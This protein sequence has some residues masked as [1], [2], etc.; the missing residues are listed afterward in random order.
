MPRA[1]EEILARLK[2][3]K[4]ETRVGGMTPFGEELP[5]V[6]GVA[7]EKRTAQLALIAES[8]NTV[9]DVVWQQLLF[10]GSGIRHHLAG[11]GPSAFGT[12][13]ILAVVD[14]PTGRQIRELVERLARDFAIFSRVDVNIVTRDCLGDAEK[15]DDALAPLLPRC[16]SLLGKEISRQEVQRFWADL[17]SNVKRAAEELDDS[18]SAMREEAGRDAADA[19]IGES[20]EAEDLPSPAPLREMTLGNFRSIEK[21]DV[22]LWDVNVIH[23]PNGGGKTSV[24]EAMELYWAGTSQRKPSDVTP[25]DY[26][27]HLPSNG[28]GKFVIKVGE[29]TIDHV[30]KKAEAELGRCVLTHEAMTSLVDDDP[31]RRFAGL[32]NVTGLEVPDLDRRTKELVDAA[33]GKANAA[34]SEAGIEPLERATTRSLEHLEEALESEFLRTLLALPDIEVL[35]RTLASVSGGAYAPKQW[36]GEEK[37]RAQLGDA[38][39]AVAEAAEDRIGEAKV[40]RRLDEAAVA[41]DALLSG[42][43]QAAGATNRLLQAIERSADGASSGQEEAPVAQEAEAPITVDLAARWLSHARGVGEAAS[44]FREDAE[45]VDDG[46]WSKRLDRYASALDDAWKKAPEGELEILS[47]PR[48]RA[49]PRQDADV[50]RSA[51][52]EAGFCAVPADPKAVAEPL[53][54][55]CETLQLHSDVLRKVRTQLRGHPARSFGAHR[56]T[57]M[58]SLCRFELAKGLRRGGPILETSERMVSELLDNRLAPIVRELVTAIV[59]FEWYFKPLQM[60]TE[61]KKIVFGGL[62][63]DRADLDARLLLNSA[64][65]TVLGVAWFLALHM[66]QPKERRRVLILDDPTSG[67]DNA[68]QAG[69]VSTLRAFVRLLE[70]EQVVVTTHDDAVAAVLV[71]ELAVVDGWPHSVA[72]LRFQRDKNDVSEVS[73]ED[74]SKTT[75]KVA[76]ETK[77]LGLLADA[78]AVG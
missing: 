37:L 51:W 42:R 23:G 12:P 15:L 53:K 18:F 9:D 55:L 45:A 17:R 24:V 7:W 8:E 31:K 54:E 74:R 60:S 28:D 61:K 19:L 36:S 72:Q 10:A 1:T 40:A 44:R 29:L 68:N 73:I 65:R 56:K 41:V 22:S 52:E 59:R 77:R 50:E 78:P 58:D 70:P 2:K 35:E 5:L 14:P 3:L 69:F 26:E 71:E 57:V 25:A 76:P 30:S 32:L 66:L 63:T 13:V 21:M 38:D 4:F 39:H 46:D 47:R 27:K 64:E 33:K 48:Q 49:L 34:L 43:L 62:A 67:F 11:D 20:A 16:R 75:R 6:T